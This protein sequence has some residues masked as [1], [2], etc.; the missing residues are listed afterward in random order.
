MSATASPIHTDFQQLE[1]VVHRL[2]EGSRAFARLG[3]D[4]RIEL[5]ERM[6]SG[7]IEIAEQ[8]AVAACKAKGVDPE[9][10]VAGEEWISGPMV[11]LRILRLTTES[12]REIK[13]HGAPVIAR[14]DC[15]T[16]P[17]GRLA[18]KVY[19]RNAMD[20]VL[21]AKHVAHCHMKPGVTFDNLRDHQASFYRKPHQGRLCV[22]LGGGNI[23][24]IP[25]TDVIYKMFVEGTVCILKMNPVNAYLGPFLERAFRAAIEK[26][27]LAV[28]Y[29]GAE[30]GA[31]LVN[32]PEVDEI[33]ITGSDRTHDLMV[34]GQPGTD[35]EARKRR[36]EPL[37]KK[38][39]TSELGNISPVIAVPGPF[40]EAELEF[41]A[42]SVAGAVAHNASFNCNAAKLLVT[43]R[44]WEKRPQLLALIEKSLARSEVRKAYYPGA[45]QRWAQFTEGRQGLKLVGTPRP[46]QL[47]WA[48]LPD[49]DPGK[50]GDRV[51][52]TE[53][54][55]AVLSETGLEGTDPVAYL[56]RAVKLCNEQLWGTLCATLVVHPRTLQDPAMGAAVDKA[57][58]DLRYGSVCVNT[59]PGA[60]FGAGTMPWGAH[61]SST[62]E[63]IQSGRGWVH[64]TLMLE[65]IEKVVLRAPVK[66]FPV[67]PWFPG[68]R[69]LLQLGK[70]LVQLETEPSWLKVPGVASAA[71]KA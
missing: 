25:P 9:S 30:E 26:G 40:S 42:C 2:K 67:A 54:W 58:T 1:D 63:D 22:V 46:G 20:S 4:E 55:C 37:L 17:D 5:C 47:A 59:W 49:V 38:E 71:M 8:S 10:P 19:P 36:H 41:Q 32:H 65:D 57:I 60:V 68:H 3:I 33:H 24:A 7:Y 48:I 31:H 27:Y 69:S 21:L 61:P 39:I 6:R 29:G 44:E 14:P 35:R 34:W 15:S 53:P 28:T 51:F 64:N 62:L 13:R 11:T 56:E 70:K 12:L 45:E 16:L 18:V 66:T 52:T 50:P 23:N 43:P